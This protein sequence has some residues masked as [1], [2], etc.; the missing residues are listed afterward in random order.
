MRLPEF[1]V[2]QP[3]ATLMVFLA[4]LI[5]GGFSLRLLPV[6]LYPE[7]EPP[8][9]TLLTTWPGASASDVESEVTQVIEDWVNGTNNLDTLTS[10]SLDNLSVVSCRFDWGADLDSAANDLRDK[11]ELAKRDLPDDAD[12]PVLFKFSSSTMPVLFLTVTAEES[13][14]RIYHLTD[15]TISDRLRRVPGVGAVLMY[16]GQQRRINVYFDRTKLAGY[17]LSISRIN[18]ILAGQNLNLPAGSVKRG[19]TEFFVRVPSRYTD[20]GELKRTVV[21][22]HQ[23]RPVR[24]EDVAKVSDGFAPQEMYGW[25]DHKPAMVLLLQKQTGKNTVAVAQAVQRELAEI[26]KVLPTDVKIKVVINSAESI[27]KSIDNLSNTLLVGIVLVVAVTLFFLQRL[28]SALVIA[29]TIPF[30]LILSFILMYMNDYS[31]NT[32]TLMSLAIAS[33]MVVDNAIVV[34][35]NIVRQVDRGARPGPAA[36]HGASQMGMAITASTLTTVV[37]FLPMVFLSGFVGVIFKQL[38]FVVSATLLAS[39]FTSLSMT[40]M[41]ASR[42]VKPA[43]ENQSGK[44]LLG[45][46]SHRIERFLVRLEEAYGRLVNWNLDNRWLTFTVVFL[47][48]VSSLTMLPLITTS[49]MPEIDSG[50]VSLDFRLEEGTRV[51]ETSR[52]VDGIINDVLTV[53]KPEEF[54]RLYAWC[55][56]TGQGLGVALGMD[57]AANAGQVGFKLVDPSLRGRR[58]KEIAA[59]LRQRLEKVPGVTRLRVL[60]SDPVGA[61]LQGQQKPV[62]VEI[63]GDD[64]DQTLAVARKLAGAI[65]AKP[66][67]VD[68]SVSQKEPRPE[69]WVEID[70]DKASL[71]GLTAGQVGAQVRNYLYGAE[72][73]E[74]RDAGDGYDIFT[75]FEES[76]RNRIESLPQAPIFTPDGRRLLLGSLARIVEQSGPV[77]IERKNLEK[78]ITVEADLLNISLGQGQKVVRDLLREIDLPAGVSVAFGGELKEQREAFGDLSIL[79]ALGIVLVYMVMASLFGNLRDPLIIMFS[80]PFAFVGVI[81]AFRLTGVS[82]GVITFMGVVMLMGIV[83][84]NAIVLLDYTKLLQK[85]G[86]AL[87]EAVVTAGR[88]R[89]RP[90]LMTTATTFFG[91]LPMA[92]STA[93]GAEVW[94]PLGITMLGGLA[95]SSLVTLIL[96]PVVYYSF[97]RRTEKP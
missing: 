69:L 64:L 25:A 29:L 96:I 56:T 14:P 53:V 85:R 8:I 37:I 83:V 78:L 91:M 76:D 46:V 15:K 45:G 89:L 10:K 58:A 19:V 28:K 30:S 72:A 79:L 9:I 20:I 71:M 93:Q 82:L 60:A 22:A 5:L 44:S 47:A 4:V 11:L 35:E 68:V 55:G 61:M 86:L 67:L 27:E 52:V 95:V 36:M 2:R 57:E 88:D 59:L 31:I 33:G 43:S 7:V 81:Y 32:V 3:M 54:R 90:V 6:D 40:P 41:L 18:Q 65:R 34:L 16:G 50:D 13:W 42:W 75:R 80:V 12:P 63:Q 21:G 38:A 17:G 39:L 73:S 84:N 87:R 66:G 48:L 77:M 92:V 24:L 70:R 1:S 94:N 23:G 26:Q 62:V 97:E 51:E 74:Y 49:F